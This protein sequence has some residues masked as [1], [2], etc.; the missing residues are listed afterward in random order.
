MPACYRHLILTCAPF[1][2]SSASQSSRSDCV[3]IYCAEVFWILWIYVSIVSNPASALAPSSD[4]YSHFTS[5]LLCGSRPVISRVTRSWKPPRT[6]PI[7]G[8]TNHISAPK[9][10]T[11]RTTDLK[12]NIDTRGLSLSLLRILVIL[13]KQPTPF[14]DPV[15]CRQVIIHRRY[16]YNQVLEGRDH[17]KVAPIGAERH[18]GCR[19][20]LLCRQTPSLP[21][22]PLLALC[23]ALA[24][25][26]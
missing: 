10:N 24:I 2:F 13:L 11:A 23:C 1:F 14:S 8:V 7:K 15:H 5:S 22:H 16:H 26:V 21:L 25:S 12:K 3:S 19:T 9:S 4:I 20:L 18:W 17:L 6:R